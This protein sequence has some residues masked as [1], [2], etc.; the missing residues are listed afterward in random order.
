MVKDFVVYSN[1]IKLL[2]ENKLKAQKRDYTKA[3]DHNKNGSGKGDMH[4]RC[5]I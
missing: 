5:N 4:Y 3:H 2:E 1:I